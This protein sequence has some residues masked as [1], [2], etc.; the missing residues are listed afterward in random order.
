M[1]P[2]S[3]NK[4]RWRLEDEVHQRLM[5][6]RTHYQ[7]NKT[8]ETR[9]AYLRALRALTDVMVFGLRPPKKP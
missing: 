6:A 1:S 7:E 5:E 2:Q 4:E 3:D 8:P 9:D